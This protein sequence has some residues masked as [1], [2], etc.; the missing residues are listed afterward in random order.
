VA[1]LGRRERLGQVVD[2]AAAHGFHR[3]VD[4]RVGGDH[5]DVQSG[6]LRHELRD[7]VEPRSLRQLEVDQG[8]VEGLARGLGERGFGGGGQPHRASDRLQ[9][10]GERGPDVLL[11]VDHED[12]QHPGS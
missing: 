1:D 6:A 11:V 7:E 4:G 8:E 2:G 3:G 12:A 10:E 9:G 5:D